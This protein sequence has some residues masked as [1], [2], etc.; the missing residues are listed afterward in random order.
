M[1]QDN[2]KINPNTHFELKMIGGNLAAEMYERTGSLEYAL[3][4]VSQDW[5]YHA[6]LKKI[7]DRDLARE[8][9]GGM[10]P[11]ASVFEQED[12]NQTAV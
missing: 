11:K 1:E 7:W 12:E 9:N 6:P 10:L 4:G 8:M 3:M 5:Y 2:L